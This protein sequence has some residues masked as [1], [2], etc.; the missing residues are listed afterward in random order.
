MRAEELIE[1]IWGS[2]EPANGAKSLQVL[3]SRTRSACGPD[4]VVRDG[5]GYR[6]G[7]TPAE[8]DC[9]RLA[10][11]MRSAR[12]ALEDD[13]PRSAEL[14]TEALALT[15]GLAASATR[16]PVRCATSVMLPPPRSPR[17]GSSSPRR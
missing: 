6:L 9:V 10:G 7:I 3:V 15:D 12:A 13:A 17:R 16:T 2:A 14:A 1:Q 5:V 8:V 11:L 4:A